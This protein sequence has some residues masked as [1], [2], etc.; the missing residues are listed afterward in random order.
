MSESNVARR[1]LLAISDLDVRVHRFNTALS[2]VGK[3][4]RW[5]FSNHVIVDPSDLVIR[6]ARPIH[7]G[8][9]GAS[10]YMGWTQMVVTPNMVGKKIAVFTAVEVKD[11]KGRLSSEQEHFIDVVKDAGGIGIV[12]RSPEEAV[13]EIKSF[14]NGML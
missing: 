6:N 5:P 8:F 13:S 2:W 12:P 1:I 4:Q 3:V 9:P 11:V 10:D 7:S 14:K